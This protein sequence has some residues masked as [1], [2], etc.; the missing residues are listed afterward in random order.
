MVPMVNRWCLLKCPCLQSN[1]VIVFGGSGAKL[2]HMMFLH[3]I[4]ELQVRKMGK[5]K[6]INVNKRDVLKWMQP[7]DDV[8]IDAL[9]HQQSL[10]NR[11][12]KVFTTM[13]YENMVNEMHEGIGMPIEKGHLKIV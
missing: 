10:G 8:L 7:M 11:V 5:S 1:L 13:A 12:D 4:S 9:L 6:N 2:G 3:L